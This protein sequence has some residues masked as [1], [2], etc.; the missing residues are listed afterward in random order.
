M[1]RED[2]FANASAPTTFT[3]GG[4]SFSV[5]IRYRRLDSF[6]A[7]FTADKDA[8]RRLLPSP[9]LSPVTSWPGRC[10]LALNAF[11]YIDTDIGPYGEFSVGIPCT[12]GSEKWPGLGVYIHRL[13][14]T[15]EIAR[16]AG[17]EV[18]GYPK[19]VCE[20]EFASTGLE[21]AVKLTLGGKLILEL[22]TEKTSL[23]L[24]AAFGLSTYTVKD[25]SIIATELR[26]SGVTRVSPNG[27]ASLTL[28]DHPM[29]DELR[30]LH[31]GPRP[32]VTGDFL[33]ARLLLPLGRKAGTI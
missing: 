31:L 27:L 6:Y 14:V 4:Q 28:G 12:L 3:L 24:G 7:V 21:H 9:R 32:L 16:V 2:I 1:F 5:P 19:F 8:A 10:L 25:G 11:N 17:I 15:S 18:W 20:M 33:D 30:S 13:P 26:S 23:G 22:R 29:A